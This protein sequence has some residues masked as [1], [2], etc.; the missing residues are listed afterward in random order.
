M[1]TQSRGHGTQHPTRVARLLLMPDLGGTPRTKR[2]VA[3]GVGPSIIHTPFTPLRF[4]QGVPPMAPNTQHEVARPLLMPD[5]GGTPRTKRSVAMG[6]GPS[7][8][9]TPF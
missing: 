7:I 6:V 9:H 3:M 2:S 4:V 5:L 8:I 1:A